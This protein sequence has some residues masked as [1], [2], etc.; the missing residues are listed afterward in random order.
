MGSGERVGWARNWWCWGA[1]LVMALLPVT[2]GLCVLPG[3]H[4]ELGNHGG[5]PDLCASLT[6]TLVTPLLFLRNLS[7]TGWSGGAIL[8]KFP[9]SQLEVFDPPPRLS[10]AV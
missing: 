9:L 4:G 1:V 3:H 2:F 5:S 7:R 10:L 6:A 8:S